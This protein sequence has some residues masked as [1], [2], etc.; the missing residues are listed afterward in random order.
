MSSIHWSPP[1]SSTR[2][3]T[4]VIFNEIIYKIPTINEFT[5]LVYE[6]I[7]PK[8]GALICRSL[9]ESSVVESSSARINFNSFTG[10]FWIRIMPTELHGVHQRWFD[11]ARDT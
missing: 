11:Y 7:P 1:Q 9:G 8:Q 2:E 10:T 4:Q 6:S 5:E 3:S